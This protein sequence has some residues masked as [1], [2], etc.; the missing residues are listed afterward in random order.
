MEECKLIC[1][2]CPLGCSLTVTL[3]GGEVVSVAG[4]T[5][6]RGEAYGRKEC[7]HPT[8]IVTGTVRITGGT[9][10][11]VSV[12]TSSDIPKEKMQ[13]CAAQLKTVVVSAPV[14]IGDVIL[15]NAAGCGVP[16]IATKNVERKQT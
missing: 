13:E 15:E 5:C 12:K 11:V 9:L 4:N 16:V 7:T 3:N 2:N 1:I 6:P 14:H 8:R 10:P